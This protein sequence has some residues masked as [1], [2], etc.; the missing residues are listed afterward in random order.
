MSILLYSIV[1]QTNDNHVVII[2]LSM[3]LVIHMIVGTSDSTF[4][5]RIREDRQLMGFSTESTFNQ[6]C[7]DKEPNCDPPTVWNMHPSLLQLPHS[8]HTHRDDEL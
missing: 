3:K 5:F 7:G 8:T 4:S 6:L 2:S 1:V